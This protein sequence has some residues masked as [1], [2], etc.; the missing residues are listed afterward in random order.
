MIAEMHNFVCFFFLFNVYV[1]FKFEIFENQKTGCK[2]S[3]NRNSSP[4]RARTSNFMVSTV[5]IV[6]QNIYL[7]IEKC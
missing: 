5:F 2:R 6:M 4:I 7:L 1:V 3:D